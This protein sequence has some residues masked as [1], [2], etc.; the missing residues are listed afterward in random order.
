MNLP[1]RIS[2]L[3]LFFQPAAYSVARLAREITT[4]RFCQPGR[5]FVKFFSQQIKEEEGVFRYFF[6]CS[7]LLDC[8]PFH[9]FCKFLYLLYLFILTRDTVQIQS[10]S[11]LKLTVTTTF[12]V[13]T[14]FPI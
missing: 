12:K 11:I 3:I 10:P 5:L 8:L 14:K 7:A 13:K 6:L 1:A 9:I 4:Q 2:C